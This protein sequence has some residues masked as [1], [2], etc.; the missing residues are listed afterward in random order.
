M[1]G[2][3]A[4]PRGLPGVQAGPTERVQAAGRAAAGTGQSADQDRRQQD[5]KNLRLPHQRGPHHQGLVG[6]NDGLLTNINVGFC[7]FNI[8]L[9]VIGAFVTS[10]I[11]TA[12]LKVG[13][14]KNHRFLLFMVQVLEVLCYLIT[15]DTLE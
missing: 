15:I 4:G 12:Y 2:G 7:L 13:H 5:P 3:A 10:I 14:K 9:S 11:N 8:A 6:K 1:P